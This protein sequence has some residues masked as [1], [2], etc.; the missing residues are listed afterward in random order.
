MRT[1]IICDDVRG[2]CVPLAAC[3]LTCA[4]EPLDDLNLFIR[5]RGTQ[6]WLI[7]YPAWELK[8]D[9]RVCF[10]FDSQF[11]TKDGRYEAEIRYNDV[12]LGIIELHVPRRALVADKD[13]QPMRQ[14]HFQAP[15]KPQG[16]TDMYEPIE[17]FQ[18][19][20]CAILEPENT[21][22]PISDD[23]KAQLCSLTL[24]RPAQLVINDGVHR[25]I[26]EWRCDAG[27]VILERGKGGTV[28]QRFPAGAVIRFEWTE[29][30]VTNAMQ[31]C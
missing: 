12:V 3:G 2:V 28:P 21:V 17:S 9:G 20:L 8:D 27:E 22:L 18:A 25:E 11:P 29:A 13:V 24:C 5:R 1:I 19:H 16:V 4:P 6:Q 30:N 15:P 26:V 10:M 23:L 31:G 7:R 14:R